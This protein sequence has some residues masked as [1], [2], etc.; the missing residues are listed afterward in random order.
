MGE[1]VE[2]MK[3]SNSEISLQVAGF[4][5]ITKMLEEDSTREKVALKVDSGLNQ[6]DKLI[7]VLVEEL[8][9]L[10]KEKPL[11]VTCL[12]LIYI[13]MQRYDWRALFAT[14]GG[15]KSVLSCMQEHKNSA[16]VQQAA[17]A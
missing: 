10:S 6:R 2:I 5:F 3:K 1:V 11:V 15:I 17:L 13:L 14:E 12:R 16:L 7:K 9:S 4:K 8:T